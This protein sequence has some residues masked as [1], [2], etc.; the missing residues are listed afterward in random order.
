MVIKYTHYKY[1]HDQKIKT[2]AQNLAGGLLA[3]NTI[4]CN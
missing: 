4:P 1:K 3:Y 2:L